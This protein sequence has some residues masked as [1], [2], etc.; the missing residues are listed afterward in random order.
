MSEAT[1]QSSEAGTI[2]RIQTQ[3]GVSF[4]KIPE[5][6]PTGQAYVEPEKAKTRRELELE[7][8]RKHVAAAAELIKNRPPRIISEAE[9]RAQPSNVPVFRPNSL[10]SDRVASQN[11]QPVSQQ[12]GA[13]MRKVGGNVK[14]AE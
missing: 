10:H 6:A 8:G 1:P 4:E 13:L 3:D 11:G 12:L 14:A 5:T 2:R 7:T 9:R